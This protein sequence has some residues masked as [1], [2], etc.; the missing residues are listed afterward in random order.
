MGPGQCALVL[1]VVLAQPAPTAPDALPA[2]ETGRE[3]DSLAETPPAQ[4]VPLFPVKSAFDFP[5]EQIED[6]KW[7]LGLIGRQ[8]ESN[9]DEWTVDLRLAWNYNVDLDNAD[10][11]PEAFGVLLRSPYLV[12][13]SRENP[14]AV[15]L[16][17][18]G[19]YNRKEADFWRRLAEAAALYVR[20]RDDPQAAEGAALLLV[21]GEEYVLRDLA[22]DL[23]AQYAIKP[24]EK[25]VGRARTN[26]DEV[27]LDIAVHTVTSYDSLSSIR[28]LI[29]NAHRRNVGAI[30]VADHDTVAGALRARD[31]A[32]DLKRQGLIRPDFVVIAGE[33]V[34][35]REGRI[36]ALFVRDLILP[37]MTAKRTIE[38]IHRQGGLAILADP[39]AASGTKLARQYPFDGYVARPGLRRFYR[40]LRLLDEPALAGK[41]LFYTTA[42]HYHRVIE[43]VYTVLDTP[44][45]TPEG[46]KQA[47]VDGDSYVDGNGYWPIL[48][49]VSFKPITRIEKTLNYYFEAKEGLEELVAHL[50]G[51]DNVRLRVS[52]TEEFNDLMDLQL[53]ST[54]RDV[55]NSRSALNDGPRLRR[56]TVS[57][58]PVILEYSRP[59]DPLSRRRHDLYSLHAAFTF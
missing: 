56:V 43:G 44:D 16:R 52:W 25:L 12:Q 17:E 30:V 34:S 48:G 45:H 35:S 5:P 14:L 26:G 40:T 1:A 47:I 15:G 42:T 7:R 24:L 6:I 13:N 9:P 50:I 29:L 54:T 31:V 37:G 33:D 51:A 28:Q 10:S 41:P 38:E 21:K 49:V 3:P 36:L 18:A 27:A 20:N 11:I 46:L 53:I 39:A 4:R 22:L 8:V 23:G 32:A 58:G 57:Y 55:L 2:A 19:R 59:F